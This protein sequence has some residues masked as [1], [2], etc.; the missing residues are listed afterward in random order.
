MKIHN[1]FIALTLF[2]SASC[3]NGQQIHQ[4]DAINI[5]I[6]NSRPLFDSFSEVR[7]IVFD[8]GSNGKLPGMI[9]KLIVSGD[10]LFILDGHKA[11]MMFAYNNE[12]NLLFDYDHIGEANNEYLS[13][14]DIAIDNNSIYLLDSQGNKIIKL[15]R[16]GEF[17]SSERIPRLVNHIYSAQE[18]TDKKNY[19]LFDMS[20]YDEARLLRIQKGKMD[21]LMK[22]PESLANF[23][24]S[25][26]NVFQLDDT[27]TLYM[28]SY[29]SIIYGIVDGKKA[30]EYMHLNFNGLLPDT[31]VFDSL[32]GKKSKDKYEFLSGEFAY[33]YGYFTNNRYILISF[34]YN[35]RLYLCFIDK[36]SKDC[37]IYDTPCDY[38]VKELTDTNLYIQNINSENL[39]IID[40]Q[41]SQ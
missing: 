2:L 38:H 35:E 10:T 32:K 16:S 20:N 28:P 29:S 6:E 11:R 31:N 41:V 24:Y 18:S 1:L 12:G 26:Q 3:S 30:V 36:V 27:A 37:T 40:I 39:T 19:F 8:E 5:D 7:E 23:S 33:S 17:I 15:N 22:T 14:M 4:A 25:P 21:T 9:T 34:S 13:L